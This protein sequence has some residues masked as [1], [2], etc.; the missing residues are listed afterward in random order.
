MPASVDNER[1]EIFQW[2]NTVV[3]VDVFIEAERKSCCCNLPEA[4]RSLS[5]EQSQLHGSW[6]DD[7]ETLGSCSIFG[8]YKITH[9]KIN[10]QTRARAAQLIHGNC[11]FGLQFSCLM[12]AHRPSRES[13]DTLLPHHSLHTILLNS[14]F[15]ISNSLNVLQIQCLCVSHCHLSI[16]IPSSLW[17]ACRHRIAR[18]SSHSVQIFNNNII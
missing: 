13:D 14:C 17:A 16:L 18:I 15:C 9:K 12:A 3:H 4:H 7:A 5:R 11:S 6:M 8:T 1:A 2:I 10:K